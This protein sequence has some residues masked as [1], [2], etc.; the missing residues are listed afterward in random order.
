M[1]FVARDVTERKAEEILRGQAA[2]LQQAT[3]AS[4]ADGVWVSDHRGRVTYIN[5]AGVRLLDYDSPAQLIGSDAH[6]IFHH[7]RADG[8]EYPADECPITK[9]RGDGCTRHVQEDTFWRKDG[10]PLSVA[11]SAAAIDLTDGDGDVVAF[12]DITAMHS[13]RERLHREFGDIALF[14]EIRDALATGGFAMY[15]QPIVDVGTGQTVK[16]ELLIRMLRATGEVVGPDQFLPAAEKYGLIMEIDRWVFAQAAT[17]AAGGRT[18]TVNIAASSMGDVSMLQFIEREIA[19]A[20]ADPALLT[21]EVTE[22]AVMTDLREGKRFADRLVELG[23]SFALDDFGTGYG[24]LTYLR[25]L[26][27]AYLKIDV[28]FIKNMVSSENDRR[29][30]E[31]IVSIAKSLGKKTIAEGVEDAA[32]FALLPQLAIDYG[33][34][35]FLGRP[36][37][38]DDPLRSI[39]PSLEVTL[40]IRVG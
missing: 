1:Y 39:P 31:T 10:L 5:P 34:G 30:V 16:H 26:P 3:L 2:S 37:P 36:A 33:Q 13:E 9:V 21:F 35:Y 27:I 20:G 11:Y 25:E 28:Q 38:W 19:R 18:V 15:A 22:T 23:C 4:V 7:S 29:L 24:S 40:P 6:A 12:R 32:T 8:A 17:F 14:E